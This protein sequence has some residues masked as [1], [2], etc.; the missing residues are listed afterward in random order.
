MVGVARIHVILEKN[1]IKKTFLTT[2][3]PPVEK[4]MCQKAS[5]I[6]VIP[7]YRDAVLEAKRLPLWL[8]IQ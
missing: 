4:L 5:V 6:T 8:M 3:Q 2:G 7:F 1:P